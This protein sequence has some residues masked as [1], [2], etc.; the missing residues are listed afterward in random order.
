MAVVKKWIVQ[1]WLVVCSIGFADICIQV[2]CEPGV[3]VFLDGTFKGVSNADDGGLILSGVSPG[4]H[5]IKA[6]REGFAPQEDRLSV[7]EGDMKVYTLQRFVPGVQVSQ[8]GE[9]ERSGLETENVVLEECKKWTADLGNG[10][11]MELM[12]ISSGTFQMGSK[13]G[14]DDETPVHTVTISRPFW[15]GRTEVTQAQYQQ[16]VW[17]NSATYQ[18]V[19]GENPVERVSW[20]DAMGF[21][22]RLTAR[23]RHAGRLPEGCEYTLPTEAQWEYAC[24]AGTTGNYAGDLDAMGWYSSNADGKLHP[25]A[26][27]QPNAFG[28]YDMHGNVWEW[29][30]DLHDDA[31]YGKSTGADPVNSSSGSLRVFRGGGWDSFAS[32]CRSAYC[33]E[34]SPSGRGRRLGFR[35]CLVRK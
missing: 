12:P 34:N 10:V 14:A 22:K 32:V 5:S 7:K 29:C 2:P 11:L 28:L 33:G 27:K 30:L 4:T 8:E 18:G 1:V 25:V 9:A 26:A 24:R 31:F 16:V 23:E 35:V 21:C 15:L 3:K 6:V 17:G 19:E 13:D 20:N